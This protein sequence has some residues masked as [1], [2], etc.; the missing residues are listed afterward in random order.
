MLFNSFQFAVFFLIFYALYLRLGHRAQNR[1]LLI[2]GCIFYGAWSWKFLLLLFLTMTID[3]FMALKISE[4]ADQKRKKLF[5]A[6]S[7]TAN[8]ATLGFFKY[9]NFFADSFQTLLSRLEIH[10]ALPVLHILLPIGISFYTFQAMSYTIDTYR[11]KVAAVKN[12]FDF[13][14]FVT[15][16]P[17]LVAGPIERAAHL[18]PQ[19]LS[20]RRL[21]FEKFY[22]GFYLFFWGLFKKIVIADNLAKIADAVFNSSAPYAGAHVLIGTYAFAFQI[23]CDFSGYTDMARGL[24]KMMGF[25]ILHNFNLPYFSKNPS[26]FW[27]RWHISLSTWL[28]D[29]LYIPLGG[30][31]GGTFRTCRNLLIVMLLGGL[32]H[33]AAWHFVLWGAYHGLLL[34][35]YRVLEPVIKK[36]PSPGS[37]TLQTAFKWTNIFFFFNLVCLGWLFFR[38][39]SIGQIGAMLQSLFFN[40]QPDSIFIIDGIPQAL[41]LTGLLLGMHALQARKNNLLAVFE[42][43]VF[44][45]W[46]LYI[47]AFYLM[48]GLA[49]GA[50][51][52][53]IYFQF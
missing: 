53:F 5:L 40:F 6:L 46:G 16:F 30:N 8:L 48:M 38:A 14:V 44:P 13:A 17:Q 20:P 19:I 51:K 26:D 18:M 11:G 3:Y 27:R 37:T 41:F 43:A 45:R 29:Y 49:T 47:L 52:Q 10:A 15:F 7:I 21:S 25:D 22:E 28:R 12:Y 32:W 9:Y 31:T 24:G 35:L 1:L 2:A 34:I 23:L 36:I 42:L 50:A 33:G 4:A 39:G